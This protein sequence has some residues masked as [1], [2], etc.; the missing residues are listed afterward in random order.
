MGSTGG[1]MAIVDLMGSDTFTRKD[2]ADGARELFV[3]AVL[4]V[5][6]HDYEGIDEEMLSG[7]AACSRLEKVEGS[8]CADLFENRLDRLQFR[9][10]HR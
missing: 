1:L 3:K 5:E 4:A 6:C 2:L 10:G 8:E 7:L 9:S